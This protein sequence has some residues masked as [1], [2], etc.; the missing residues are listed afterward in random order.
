MDGELEFLL[1]LR[2][3]GLL[4]GFFRLLWLKNV[5]KNS[6]TLTGINIPH[7]VIYKYRKPVA[8]YFTC[9]ESVIKKKNKKR[10]I[11]TTIDEE[12]Q[13]VCES[14]SGVVA[15]YMTPN[16]EPLRQDGYITSEINQTFIEASTLRN[17]LQDANLLSQPGV[18]Q[19]FSDPKRPDEALRNAGYNVT[20]SPRGLLIELVT[21]RY[22][23]TDT[24]IPFAERFSMESALN[25]DTVTSHA[26]K[27]LTNASQAIAQHLETLHACKLSGMSLHFT[28]DVSNRLWL[29]YC[30]KLQLAASTVDRGLCIVECSSSH[31]S[32]KHITR[33]SRLTK[34][35]PI[36]KIQKIA[37]ME[38]AN[39]RCELCQQVKLRQECSQLSRRVALFGLHVLDHFTL[40]SVGDGFSEAALLNA[41]TVPPCVKM[42]GDVSMFKLNPRE[43][44]DGNTLCCEACVDNLLQLTENIKVEKN[45]SIVK[46]FSGRSKSC[47]PS[48]PKRSKILPAIGRGSITPSPTTTT[49]TSI[50]PSWGLSELPQSDSLSVQHQH[51][52]PPG[53][54]RP[55]FGGHRADRY[56][57][58]NLK[59]CCDLFLQNVPN[60]KKKKQ[61]NVWFPRSTSSILNLIKIKKCKS[62]T[63]P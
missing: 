57:F 47:L 14:K 36:K 50:E 58:L 16:Y 4:A 18:L 56:D 46:P 45:G 59:F 28:I 7:S 31:P 15:V 2:N 23:M 39:Q 22:L 3:E 41:K 37:S 25:V 30:N 1:E 10:L 61:N 35:L 21:S 6:S 5:G 48:S 52:Q 40:S 42:I 53:R 33:L 20:W 27:I 34:R 63:R 32:P 55:H 19:H 49:T 8:W 44:L 51:Y 24:S 12:L 26:R 43:W 13:K 11:T 29:R 60:K 17:T 54:V 62:Y 38:S 9:K